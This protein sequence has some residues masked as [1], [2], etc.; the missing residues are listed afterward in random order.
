M[1][2]P[3][4]VIIQRTGLALM[5]QSFEPVGGLARGLVI[6][7]SEDRWAALIKVKEKQKNVF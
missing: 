7:W 4:P 1:G 6:S 5:D 2:F 3:A